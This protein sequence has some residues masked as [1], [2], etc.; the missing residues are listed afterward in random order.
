MKKIAHFGAFDHDSFGDLLFPLMIESLLP[1][2]TITHVSPT[3]LPAPWVDARPS[4]SVAEA[5]ER[6]DWD[7]IVVGG[8]DII[9]AGAW[10]TERWKRHSDMPGFHLASLWAG[11]AFLSAKRN[12]PAAWNAPGVPLPFEDAFADTVRLAL[13]ASDSVSVRD[14]PSRLHLDPHTHR[15]IQIVPDTAFLLNRL[16]P[17]T[18]SHRRIVLALSRADTHTHAT[19]INR[20]IAKLATSADGA[21]NE[22]TVL[23]LTRWEFPALDQARWLGRCKIK[24][25]L[26]HAENR[27]ETAARLIGESAGYV[28]NS[29]HGLV[30]A[31]A[32]GVPAVL[33]PPTLAW[34]PHKY[35]GFLNAMGLNPAVHIAETWDSAADKLL[36]QARPVAG[37]TAQNTILTHTEALRQ[38]L[39]DGSVD[40]QAAWKAITQKA[41]QDAERLCLRGVFP[42]TLRVLAHRPPTPSAREGAPSAPAA[43]TAPVVRPPS[44]LDRF[45][46]AVHLERPY[47]AACRMY[48]RLNPC[49][50]ASTDPAP[51]RIDVLRKQHDQLTGRLLQDFLFS[52]ATLAFST[53]RPARVSVV[54][55]LFN[56]A[57]LTLACL[58]SLQS[59]TLPLEII[60]VD[61]A[62]TDATGTLLSRV[63]GATCIRN[64]TNLHFL[65]A[66]NQGAKQASGTFLL[67]L[68]SDTEVLPGAIER[69]VDRIEQTPGAGAVGGRL[70]L[71][72]GFL[73]EAGGMVWG[74]GTCEGY[75]RGAHPDDGAGLFA[76]PVDY[77]SGAFLL[78]PLASWRELGG[79]DEA[80]EPAYYE[81]TDYCFRL[82]KSGKSV[83]YEPR[84]IIRHYEFGSADAG[85]SPVSHMR[86]NRIRFASL[87]ADRLSRRP[88]RGACPP[89]HT[90]TPFGEGRPRIL[91][92]DE[93]LPQLAWGAG[94]PRANQL[95]RTLLELGFDVTLYPVNAA[96]R[97]TTPAEARL[98]IPDT[99]E[100]LTGPRYGI[101][102][103]G[104][105]LRERKGF[106][107]ALIISRPTTMAAVT[108]ILATNPQC[109]RDLPIL[110]DAEA[111]FSLREIREA[112]AEG[113]P[114]PERDAHTRIH[115]ELARCK[116]AT[117]I[118]TVSREETTWFE[119]TGIPTFIVGH[120]VKTNP[121]TPG[122][123]TRADVLFLGAINGN[124]GPNFDTVIEFL[125]HLWPTLTPRLPGARFVIAGTNRSHRLTQEPLPDR[126][127]VT[128]SLDTLNPV[129]DAARIFVAPTRASA[130][131]PLKLI[132]AAAHGVPIVCSSLLA[133]QLQWEDGRE[134]SVADDASTFI[135]KCV[136]L[137]TD[138]TRWH[139]QRDAARL[140][141]EAQ[142]SHET[143]KEQLRQ[144]CG[145]LGRT[146]G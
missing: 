42:D 83:W 110:Y 115:R 12:V 79:F 4:I 49:R 41:G 132:E 88:S 50:R 133:R 35:S 8:G 60:L 85:Q 119:K 66:C 37:E 67:L 109:V 136:A 137:Y 122:W 70:I 32:Y 48:G 40:K 58:K 107:D 138:Q 126:V 6:T 93:R 47:H 92:C 139:A 96:H 82:W 141:V 142:Y 55:V 27:L 7:G 38:R 69:A 77:C 101:D 84:S 145:R 15:P 104:S 80:F 121:A 98:D 111:L 103:L 13:A 108:P 54:I 87:H 28:G 68:N 105:L 36:R 46:H 72:N 1:D 26:S 140:A 95:M 75:L 14:V 125:E 25:P 9:Q 11:A 20:M 51:K 81:E 61:N 112:Q 118:L 24:A 65:R 143:F 86:T 90:R 19:A 100:I 59:C 74:D 124:S 128:G 130:G 43:G 62:S 71:P 144:A 23:P 135:E 78:T 123:E 53:P 146:S 94:Y 29:L 10:S 120:A 97:H 129:Y 114:L 39:A 17:A 63:F 134:L 99:V 64:T 73:Q 76:R 3:G 56:R 106:Y 131:I 89:V 16:W 102:G 22:V 44:A 113:A 33:V 34:K 31:L 127:V 52:H 2:F 30:T 21:A 91:I 5:V 45:I 116:H 18:G 117:S 57:E